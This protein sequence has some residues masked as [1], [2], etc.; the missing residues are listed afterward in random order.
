M[1]HHWT[2]QLQN[3]I[4]I[5]APQFMRFSVTGC[6]STAVHFSLVAFLVSIMKFLPITANVIAFLIAFIVSYVGHKNFTFATQ[7]QTVHQQALLRFF[8]I[9]T[10]SFILNETLYYYFLYALH[11][12]YLLA[13][14]IV[15]SSVSC[16]TFTLSRT[17]AFKPQQRINS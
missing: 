1:T 13:L 2:K 3:K 12:N 7:Y 15:L 6:L 4:S 14:I 8:I 5:L 16:F 11:L 9:A 10:I 17:W